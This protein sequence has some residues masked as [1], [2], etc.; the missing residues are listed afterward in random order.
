M[1][2]GASVGQGPWSSGTPKSA[3]KTDC[4]P[5]PTLCFALWYNQDVPYAQ[6]VKMHTSAQFK[7]G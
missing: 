3:C 5:D 1:I 7:V 6:A 4:G 2:A